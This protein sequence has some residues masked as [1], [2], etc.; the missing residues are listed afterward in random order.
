MIRCF[1]IDD[2]P[3]ALKQLVTYISKVPFLELAGQFLSAAEA[4]QA[5]ERILR[6]APDTEPFTGEEAMAYLKGL[7]H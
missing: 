2:E 4:R 7:N 1:A 3:L 6:A 5:L